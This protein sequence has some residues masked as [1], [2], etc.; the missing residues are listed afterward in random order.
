MPFQHIELLYEQAFFNRYEK[1]A[2]SLS[3]Q[4]SS[5]D[6]TQKIWRLFDQHGKHI[7]SYREDEG[8]RLV[9]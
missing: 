2:P 8:I 3:R 4:Y 5:F 1:Q 6:L 9:N 7:A